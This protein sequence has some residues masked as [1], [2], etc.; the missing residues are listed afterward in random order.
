[1]SKYYTFLTGI[2]LML[3]VSTCKQFTEGIDEYLSYWASDAFIKSATIEAAH[4]HDKDGITSVAS[5]KDVEITLRLQNPQSFSFVMPTAAEKRPIVD[6]THLS[7]LKPAVTADYEMTQP[8]ADTLRLTYKAA[9][10]QKA[11]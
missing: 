8:T 3:M 5:Y 7:D 2:L 4:S 6:F 1:M 9:F 10:L 11:E